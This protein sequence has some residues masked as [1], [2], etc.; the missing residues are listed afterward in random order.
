MEA[1]ENDVPDR[2]WWALAFVL[3]IAATIM[4]AVAQWLGG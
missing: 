3:A 1:N 4:F 2:Y